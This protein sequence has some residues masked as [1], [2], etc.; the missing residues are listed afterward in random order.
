M[1]AE[2]ELFIQTIGK[3]ESAGEGLRRVFFAGRRSKSL[4]CEFV[5]FM[6]PQTTAEVARMLL[7]LA[8]QS[9]EDV[10]E[11]ALAEG[12]RHPCH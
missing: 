2:P 11:L 12:A 5:A 4:R 9:P 10:A 8:S 7:Y 3:Y 1:G 6:G